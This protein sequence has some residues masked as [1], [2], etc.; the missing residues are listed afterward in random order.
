MWII[1]NIS[2]TAFYTINCITIFNISNSKEEFILDNS[3]TENY[4]PFK[5]DSN[6]FSNDISF[7]IE[8]RAKPQIIEIIKEK[9]LEEISENISI[10]DKKI[11]SFPI[12]T[13]NI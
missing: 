13:K 1:R 12:V 4:H 11:I 7:L 10:Q 3:I 9:H 5:S 2:N 6:L 8:L